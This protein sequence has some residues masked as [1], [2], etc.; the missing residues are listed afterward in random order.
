MYDVYRR[1]SCIMGKKNFNQL[2]LQPIILDVVQKLKFKYPTDI[3][4]KV[5]PQVLEGKSVIGQSFT[6]SGKTHAFRSEEH[7]SE[8]QSRGHLVCRLLLA[9]KKTYIT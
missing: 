9:K 4:E 6:G 2:S 7:T 8:L 3:Q 5:I 1:S